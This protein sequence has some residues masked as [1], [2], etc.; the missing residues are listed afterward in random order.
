MTTTTATTAT[1]VASGIAYVKSVGTSQ[2]NLWL[3]GEQIVLLL[4]A[5][6][7][8]LRQGVKMVIAK[9]IL[10]KLDDGTEKPITLKTMQ[11]KIANAVSCYNKFADAK[12]A[13]KWS[14][15]ELGGAKKK[16][17]KKANINDDFDPIET[18]GIYTM[19]SKKN[20]DALIK[21]LI[22]IK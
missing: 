13:N 1:T 7:K 21:A 11:N 15:R 19:L 9:S 18:A 14:M 3:F 8:E 17:A 22:A 16:S 6:E 4:E 5:T 10:A 20:K 12:S 2:E